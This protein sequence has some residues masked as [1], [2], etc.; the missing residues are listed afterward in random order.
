MSYKQDLKASL[1]LFII[2]I[3]LAVITESMMKITVPAVA[4]FGFT[5]ALFFLFRS[6]YRQGHPI[7]K[8]CNGYGA[9]EQKNMAKAIKFTFSES[10]W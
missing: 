4:L 3:P 8:L 5:F 1:L 9:I 2:T 6:L 10:N 7:C